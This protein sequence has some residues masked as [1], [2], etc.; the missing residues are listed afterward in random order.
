MWHILIFRHSNDTETRNIFP[1]VT[2]P[3]FDCT[4]N[5]GKCFEVYRILFAIML[6]I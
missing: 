2:H 1:A 3:A 5:R 6:V 4:V